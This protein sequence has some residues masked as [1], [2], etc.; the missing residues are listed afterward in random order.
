MFRLFLKTEDRKG[1][2]FTI[3]KKVIFLWST[4]LYIRVVIKILVD[5][6]VKFASSPTFAYWRSKHSLTWNRNNYL[7]CNLQLMWNGNKPCRYR[8]RNSSYRYDCIMQLWKE[9][10]MVFCPIRCFVKLVVCLTSTDRGLGICQKHTN[11][12]IN[13]ALN[14]NLFETL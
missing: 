8:F 1:K 4:F 3:L 14:E 10:R 13:I 2:C 12:F 9:S 6:I 11:R 7:T 5:L